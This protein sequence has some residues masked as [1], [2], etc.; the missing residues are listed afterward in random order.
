MWLQ[1]WI[2]ERYKELRLKIGINIDFT[3]EKAKKI[4]SYDSEQT[5]YKILNELEES[6]IIKVKRSKKDKRQKKYRIVLDLKD[7]PYSYLSIPS[8]YQAEPGF[9][10]STGSTVIEGMPIFLPAEGKPFSL[11]KLPSKAFD[12]IY[13]KKSE[14]FVTIVPEK[15]AE[16]I[17][18]YLTRLI[19][20]YKSPEAILNIIKKKQIDFNKVIR[21]LNSYQKRYLGALLEIL[22][23]HKGIT[24]KLY[25]LTK[26]DKREFSIFPRKV[27]KVSDEYKKIAKKWRINLNIDVVNL[28][29]L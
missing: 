8:D 29:E 27:K 12:K 23:E 18:E 1:K 22:N 6:K 15:A 28:D 4:L 21:E 11:P 14:R 2:W 25:E 26:N 3:Y 24:D 13:N 10:A 17:E 20:K 19:Q 7:V 16:T 9:L 5:I